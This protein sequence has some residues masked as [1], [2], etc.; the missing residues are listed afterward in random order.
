MLRLVR[1]RA[2]GTF[3]RRSVKVIAAAREPLPA[4]EGLHFTLMRDSLKN[5][6]AED[7]F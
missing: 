2:R 7:V 4:A 3:Y 6:F 5:T 1:A